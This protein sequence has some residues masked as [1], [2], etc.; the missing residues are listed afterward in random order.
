MPLFDSSFP[1]IASCLVNNH[2]FSLGS[3]SSSGIILK[4]FLTNFFQIDPIYI[5]HQQLTNNWT[6]FVCFSFFPPLWKGNTNIETEVI[7]GLYSNVS[8]LWNHTDISLRERENFVMLFE[9]YIR[10]DCCL[11]VLFN[12]SSWFMI[13]CSAF[14]FD[15]SHLWKTWHLFLFY[16]SYCLSDYLCIHYFQ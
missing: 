5:W 6:M 11:R 13:F 15:L 10:L 14:S 3:L 12:M 7:F 8:V 9:C 1:L 2:V 4:V 16:S